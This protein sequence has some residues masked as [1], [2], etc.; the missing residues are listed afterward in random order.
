MQR[1]IPVGQL[2]AIE[3]ARK[4]RLRSGGGIRGFTLPAQVPTSST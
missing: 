2:V 3:T 1:A 4:A